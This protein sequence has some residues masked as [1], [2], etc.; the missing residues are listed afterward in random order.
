MKWLLKIFNWGIT[1]IVLFIVLSNFWIINSNK[2]KIF[3]S[4]VKLPQIDTAIVFGTSKNKIGG[5]YSSFFENRIKAA[6][7]LY[8]SGKVKVLLLSGSKDKNYYN[9]AKDMQKAL[10]ELKVASHAMVLDSLGNRSIETIQRA[11]VK[12]NIDNAIFITQE[13]H[14]YRVLFLAEHIKINAICYKATFSESSY[15]IKTVIREILAR[16]KA[17]LDTYIFT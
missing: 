6:A 8:H 13:Y 14:A 16:P 7:K 3:D 9:E 4:V 15:F 12:Y 1:I 5:G 2:G 11:K 17:V 10:L